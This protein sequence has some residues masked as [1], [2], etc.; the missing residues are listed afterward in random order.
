MNVLVPIDTGVGIALYLGHMWLFRRRGDY[1]KF[2]WGTSS[3]S[4]A[5]FYIAIKDKEDLG[6]GPEARQTPAFFL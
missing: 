1:I 2:R 5:V 3:S 4:K 6:F